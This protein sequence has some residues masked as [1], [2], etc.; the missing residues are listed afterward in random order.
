[1]P[2]GDVFAFGFISFLPGGALTL[3]GYETG[4]RA[5]CLQAGQF[6]G[7]SAPGDAWRLDCCLRPADGQANLIPAK[8]GALVYRRDDLLRGLTMHAPK[9]LRLLRQL[10]LVLRLDLR[11]R[12]VS[13][14]LPDHA[15]FPSALAWETTFGQDNRA[16]DFS[17]LASE[18][19]GAPAIEITEP[20]APRPLWQ[21]SGQQLVKASFWLNPSTGQGDVAPNSTYP[22]TPAP[23]SLPETRLSL[24]LP[25]VPEEYVPALQLLSDHL[26]HL[27]E[28]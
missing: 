5:D 7:Y 19:T 23:A 1:M 27:Q 17:S 15:L 11:L 26:H 10:H 4:S 24:P 2:W 20:L 3:E 14:V 8:L 6:F 21:G 16:A 12:D 18:Y 22:L 13:R 9:T 28:K 25:L